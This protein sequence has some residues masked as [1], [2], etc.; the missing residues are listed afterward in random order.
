ME[1][2][3]NGNEAEKTMAA[4]LSKPWYY[5]MESWLVIINIFVLLAN[6][7]LTYDISYKPSRVR[8]KC[9]AEAEFAPT[10]TL[11]SDEMERQTF[12]DKYYQNCIRRFGVER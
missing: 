7:L 5:K 4:A 3:I 2:K 6:I 12:I 11:M 8:E 9:I 10:A 1:H